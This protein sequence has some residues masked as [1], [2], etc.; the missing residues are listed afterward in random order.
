MR[1]EERSVYTQENKC[2]LSLVLKKGKRK[3]IDV[4]RTAGW[5][6]VLVLVFAVCS[7]RN[8]PCLITEVVSEPG[9]RTDGDLDGRHDGLQNS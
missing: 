6:G 1:K 4:E 8:Y 9:I 2:C 3:K 7:Y 5:G